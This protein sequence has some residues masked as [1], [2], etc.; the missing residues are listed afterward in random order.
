M[1]GV[2]I[3]QL[4][5]LA[6]VIAMSGAGGGMLVRQSSPPSGLY[7]VIRE[8]LDRLERRH[9]LLMVRVRQLEREAS[10][11]PKTAELLSIPRVN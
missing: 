2:D 4:T 11:P 9:E 5:I 3:K 1:G 6:M 7:A 10:R 8:E